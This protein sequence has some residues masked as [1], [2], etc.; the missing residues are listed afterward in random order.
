M[1]VMATVIYGVSNMV[2]YGEG[3]KTVVQAA[4]D[5]VKSFIGLGVS[6]TLG[7]AAVH[8]VAGTSLALGTAFLVPAAA[9]VA[10]G[11]VS[12]KIWNKIFFKKQETP[13]VKKKAK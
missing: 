2:K 4:K 11:Y 9:G 12:M 1:G 6:S 10:T 8:A 13:A 7:V 5:T 3:K